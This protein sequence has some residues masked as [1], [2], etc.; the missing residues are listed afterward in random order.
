MERKTLLKQRRSAGIATNNE[1]LELAQ[2][3]SEEKAKETNKDCAGCSN[4]INSCECKNCKAC[5]Y[6]IGCKNCNDIAYCTDCKDS[7]LLIGCIGCVDCS[8]CYC[9]AGLKNKKYVIYNKQFS[10]KEFKKILLDEGKLMNFG[11][12][13]IHNNKYLPSL[14]GIGGEETKEVLTIISKLIN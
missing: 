10:K 4:C 2:F 5:F 8:H 14:E 7:S 9:C 6:S 1:L 11:I 12:E 13:R 3:E